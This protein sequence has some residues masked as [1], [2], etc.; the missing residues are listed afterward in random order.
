MAKQPVSVVPTGL[1]HRAVYFAGPNRT[2]R[3]YVPGHPSPVVHYRFAP[4]GS[5]AFRR[6]LSPD[7]TSILFTEVVYLG[8]HSGC[9]C[10][11]ADHTAHAAEKFKALRQNAERR[12]PPEA[13]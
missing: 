5:Q 3:Y 2:L 12:L 4:D 8:E 9:T 10:G 6:V 1:G 11:V 13:L 7:G